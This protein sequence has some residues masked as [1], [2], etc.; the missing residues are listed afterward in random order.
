MYSI[1]S[2]RVERKRETDRERERERER[3]GERGG[4]EARSHDIPS[5]IALMICYPP[6]VLQACLAMGISG[7][8]SPRLYSLYYSYP[9]LPLLFVEL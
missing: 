4:E 5:A 8:Q 1:R 9:T 6:D 3:E 2:I 7:K